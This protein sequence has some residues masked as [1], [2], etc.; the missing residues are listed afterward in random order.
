MGS[1]EEVGVGEAEFNILFSGFLEKGIFMQTITTSELALHTPEYLLLTEERN[2]RLVLQ[3]NGKD[4]A[5]IIPMEDYNLIEALE[6]AADVA[7]AK[8]A[9]KEEGGITLEELSKKYGL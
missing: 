9:M 3:R 4:V 7:F 1:R 8:E 2:E 5:A 6:D